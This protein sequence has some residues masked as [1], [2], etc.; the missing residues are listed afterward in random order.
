MQ[1]QTYADLQR[2]ISQNLWKIPSD[3]DLVVGIP[4]SGMLVASLV[5][6]ARNLPLVDLEGFI[7]G[8]V[9]ESGTTRRRTTD[10][11]T[12]RRALV[13]DDSSRTGE[14]IVR[15]TE[16]LRAASR[17]LPPTTTCVVYGTRQTTAHVDIT[18]VEINKPRIFEWNVLHHPTIL[19]NACIDIDGVLCH[20]PSRQD[21]DDGARYRGFIATARPLH[22][23]SH[24][25]HALVTSRL[26]KYRRET[27]EW[28]EAQGV[29][30][31]RLI[32]L[33]LATAE[34]R[35]RQGAHAS[36]KAAYYRSSSATLFIESELPQ[37][38]QIARM[39][40]KPVLSLEGPKICLPGRLAPSTVVQ[41]F[42]NPR[43][44]ARWLRGVVGDRL[45]D[46]LRDVYLRYVENR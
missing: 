9:F 16:S 30:Y 41:R 42:S 34:E 15:A 6:L 11:A 4:R 38:E 36:H 35:R 8:R 22:I 13:V 25:V 19:A 45:V 44:F 29:V 39:S 28:L 31:D 18:M 1:L 23:P 40:G 12:I 7:A 14:A 17:N 27:E 32:M 37:A 20:D 43:L 3:I 2:D 5:A 10:P 24:R 26:E 21:N 33:D 46:R